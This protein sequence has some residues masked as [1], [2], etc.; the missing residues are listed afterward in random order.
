[1][2][3]ETGAPPDLAQWYPERFFADAQ[4]GSRRSAQEI[5]PLIVEFFHPS[6][7]VDV[8]CSVGAWLA[9]FQQYGVTDILGV[10][11]DH[12]PRKMLQIRE[13]QFLAADLRVPLRL[14]R[15]FDL[16]LCLEVA[17]HLPPE[18]ATALVGSLAALA[19]VVVFSA[20]IPFQGGTDHLNEQW[21][22]YWVERFGEVHYTALDCLRRRVWQNESVD[23]WYAQNLLCFVHQQRVQ[24][25]AHLAGGPPDPVPAL[26]HPLNYVWKAEE[27]SH[28]TG[29]RRVVSQV[30]RTLGRL[31]MERLG[32]H[33][34]S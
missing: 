6:S 21:P 2:R 23:W 1:M 5:V 29:A 7:V 14:D 3:P 30:V 17:E 10:D 24:L 27:L 4:E 31:L 26:V 11:G 32:K 9:A 20:A 8:G 12:V 25:Y 22:A 28:A 34:G 33:G 19:P 16:A 13:D 15:R 18:C